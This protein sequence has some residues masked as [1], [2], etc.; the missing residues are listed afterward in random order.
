M[1]IISSIPASQARKNKKVRK[2]L[3]EGVPSL[4]LARRCEA[5]VL[6]ADGG[7]VAAGAASGIVDRYEESLSC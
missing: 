1:T 2:L 7:V 5:A 6:F 3:G 4:A